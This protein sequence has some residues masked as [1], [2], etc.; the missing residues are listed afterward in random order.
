MIKREQLLKS[1]IHSL[2]RSVITAILGPRQCGKT[3]ISREIKSYS[4]IT[5]FDLEDP[6]DYQALIVTPKL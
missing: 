3:T 4:P 2:K 6:T 5:I 1:I